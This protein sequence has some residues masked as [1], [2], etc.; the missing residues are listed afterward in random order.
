M[1]R[2]DFPIF[3]EDPNLIYFD[4]A[5]TTLKPKTVI[6][7]VNDYYSKYTS[8][9]HRSGYDN[10]LKVDFLYEETREKVRKFL[11]A[12]LVK[13][14]IFTSGTTQSLNMIAFGFMKYYLKKGDEVIITKAEHASSTLPWM[15]LE[16]EIGIVL[17]YAKLDN[18]HCLNIEN[19]KYAITSKTKV[20]AIAHITNTIGDI[21]PLEEIGKICKDNNIYF[22][23]DAAQSIAHIKI[24]VKKLNI[25]FLAFS[26]HKMLG[27]T[28]VGVL[29]GKLSLLE[30]MKPIL[31]GGGMNS[32]FASNGNILLKDL[33]DR[34]EA[35]TQSIAS[36]IGLGVA[37]DYILEIGL[38]KITSHE[39]ELKNYFLDQVKD[40]DNVIIYNNIIGSG[41]ILFNLAGISSNDTASYLNESHICIRAG[42]HCAKIL[43]DELGFNDT[44]RIS[45]YLYNTKEEIDKLVIALKK[46]KN[47]FHKIV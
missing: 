20:V 34:L 22:V 31:Y 45:F 2:E 44:C 17:K 42:S 27:P 24:D 10:G 33:P 47:I 18:D 38:E 5:A 8:N 43:K 36:V 7:A 41:I 4:N 6:N 11:S 28:G 1:N 13:E 12:N 32:Y 9:A 29:Y 25:D 40:V 30:N 16:K 26:S 19:L 23:V 35:G 14:I 37:I 21:R 15:M 3:K 46:S 39:K